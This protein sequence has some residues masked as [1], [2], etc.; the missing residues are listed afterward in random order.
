MS[1]VP[2]SFIGG[3]KFYDKKEIKDLLAYLSVILNS[4]DE[5]SLRRILNVPNR[6]IG[7]RTLEKFQEHLAK[8]EPKER[9]TLFSAMTSNPEFADKQEKNIKEFTILIR[10]LR[11][12]F[13]DNSLKAGLLKLIDSINYLKFI[14]KQY[15]D[16]LKLADVKKNDVEALIASAERFQQYVSQ[17]TALKS[18]VEKLMLQDSQDTKEENDEDED[19]RKNEVTLMT[20][21]SSKGLEFE[22]VYLLG[23][24][25]E[26]LPHKKS[27]QENGISE[28][29]RL[30][31]VGITRAKEELIMTY[32]KERKI[33]GKN[34]VRHKSRF[35]LD[36]PENSFIEQ[37]RTT[38]GHLTPEQAEDY[39]K[40]F[41]CILNG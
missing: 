31:Y 29:L 30:A 28:E 15:D 19:I 35:L 7:N 39:K 16:N 17:K 6:G 9:P 20:L 33:Y 5:I 23:V 40:D 3:Q 32:C 4:G 37:D 8:L 1:D 14:D 18:F 22:K 38:F 11:S 10:E 13:E 21:H 2:Y 36:L 41:F 27:I 24:E 25:E 26:T 12:F 34:I